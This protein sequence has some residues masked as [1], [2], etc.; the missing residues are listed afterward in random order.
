M[1]EMLAGEHV[2]QAMDDLRIAVEVGK[3]HRSEF[4]MSRG[5]IYHERT[6]MTGLLRLTPQLPGH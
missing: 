2:V 3:G 1:G 4:I 6:E 5:M